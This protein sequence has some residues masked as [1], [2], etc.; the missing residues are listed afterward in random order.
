VALLLAER[1]VEGEVRGIPGHGCFAL[2]SEVQPRDRE[3]LG[4]EALDGVVAYR[5]ALMFGRRRVEGVFEQHVLIERVIF[6]RCLLFC[7]RVEDGSFQFGFLGQETSGVDLN[8]HVI[9]FVIV[10]APGRQRLVDAA[11]SGGLDMGA[12]VHR[13]DVAHGQVDIGLGCPAAVAV[14]IGDFKFVE[15]YNGVFRCRGVVAHA[16]KHDPDVAQ[17]RISYHRNCVPLVVGVALAEQ[18]AIADA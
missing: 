7:H 12:E 4:R 15:P 13:G 9:L 8:G 16:D 10:E 2:H 6:R 1:E 14:E 17:R 18:H 11:E 3:V 5:V